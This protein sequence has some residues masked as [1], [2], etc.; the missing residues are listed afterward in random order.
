MYIYIF[1]IYI[2]IYNIY[3]YNIYIYIIYIYT[4]YPHFSGQSI[5]HLRGRGTEGEL[6]LILQ[7]GVDAA[8]RLE[9][10]QNTLFQ[11]VEML[12]KKTWLFY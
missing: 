10:H 1:N 3:I 5:K 11:G 8:K 9:S 4:W 7:H 2:Y 6:E 12:P